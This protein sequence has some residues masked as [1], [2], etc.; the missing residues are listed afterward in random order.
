MSADPALALLSGAPVGEGARALLLGCAGDPALIGTYADRYRETFCQEDSQPAAARIA[1]DGRVRVLLGDLPCCSVRPEGSGEDFLPEHRFPADHFDRIMLRL[2]RGT[3]LVN[4]SLIEAFRMLKP[5]G[6]LLAA[7]ANQEGAKSFAK[8][9]EGHFGGGELLALKHSCRLFRFRKNA[10][11]PAEAIEDPG[12]YR[13][14][15]HTLAHPRGETR[16]RTKPGVFAYRGTDTGTALLGGL[17]PDCAGKRVLDLCCGSGPLALA[18]FARGAAEVLAV[19]ASA[20]AIACAERNFSEAGLPGKTLCADLE[21]PLPGGFDLV[22]ANPPFHDGSATDYSLP[23]RVLQAIAAALRPG[24]EAW[25]VANQFLDYA[26]PAK[27]LFG[28]VATA[29]RSAGYLIHH[30][31]KGPLEAA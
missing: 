14:L 8:R 21:A 22:L 27:P 20:T 5:G 3:A 10:P 28:E 15:T 24:G 2:G 18:A 23:A 16:Y 7:A 11:A 9:A 1:A 19:D 17:L 26:R 13:S 31:V 12:Y 6:E 30:V 29:A 4:A 25:L